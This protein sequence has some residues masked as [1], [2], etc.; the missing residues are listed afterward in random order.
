M[1]QRAKIANDDNN[2]DNDSDEDEDI[3]LPVTS[4]IIPANHLWA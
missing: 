2:D 1:T 3:V 4:Y